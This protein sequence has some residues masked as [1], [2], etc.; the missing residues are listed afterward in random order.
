VATIAS[1]LRDR[2]TLQVRSVDRLFLQAYVPRLMTSFQVVR[3]LLDRGH[4]IPSPALL[5]RIGRAYVEAIDRY[6]ADHGIPVL[7]FA[8]G[9][10]KEQIARRYFQSAE[11]E[12]RFGVVLIGVA[13]EKAIAWRGWRR[14]GRDSHPHF[15][16]GRQA[17]FVNHYYFYLRDPEWGP[18]FIKTCAYAPFPAWLYLN[19]H[20]WA[21]RQAE[22]A[23]LAFE[24]LDNGFRAAEDADALATICSRLSARDVQRFYRRWEARLPSPL[25]AEDRRRGYR[26][27]LCFRQLELSDTR[28]FDR[29]AAGRAWFEQTIR[30]Q[31]TLGRPDRVAVVFARRVDRRTPGRFH[32][33]VI[34]SGTEPAIQVHYRASKVKQYLKQGRALRTETTVNDTYDFGIG[35]LLTQANWDALLAV[36]HDTNQ[37]LLDAQLQACACAPDAA[38]LERVVLPST[39]DGQPA[40][41]L[42][43]GDPRV[44]ALLASLCAFS[45]LLEGITNRSLRTLVAGLIPGYTARQMTYDLR[46]LRRKGLIRRL[47]HSQRYE[48]TPDGRRLAVFLTKTH[49]RIV[50]PALAEL[51][52]RLPDPI[53]RHT[54]LGRPWREFEH[55]LDARIADAA[56]TA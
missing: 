32:T 43:F 17:I 22:R 2:V 8:K 39:H 29:P 5:G 15:E 51:D 20:E 52:P 36:G 19:G 40:P 10:S 3:F 18:A 9:E 46:R 28:V 31:L 34:N 56:L 38:T 21:K 23:G 55:A 26:H 42:R 44:M 11:R 53:A 7:R 14:G 30:D 33:R 48:L 6:A 25:S 37:R 45:H 35:R 27:Q 41:G 50:C 4:P 24:A 13:Q 12:G 54:A 47:A 16:F 1:L 49:T